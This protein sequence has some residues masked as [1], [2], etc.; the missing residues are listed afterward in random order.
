MLNT[1]A[2]PLRAL[3]F[4]AGG[5]A[6]AWLWFNVGW[7]APL[8]AVALVVGASLALQ[9]AGKRL[10]PVDPERALSYLESRAVGIA[11]ITAAF[12]AA[13]IVCTVA[14]TTPDT[15]VT[16]TK[17]I[18][19]TLSA[20]IVAFLSGVA[21]PSDEADEEIGE[22]VRE[23]FQSVYVRQSDKPTPG[24][25]QLITGSTAHRAIQSSLDFGLNDWSRAN[26]RKRIELLVKGKETDWVQ[27]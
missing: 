21:I 3:V 22:H 26:R 10:V 11:A 24:K 20:A 27:A 23:L 16:S 9:E 13:G 17:E 8:I 18:I 4:S 25:V 7:W 5:A 15:M 14:L 19:S 12:G 1:L 6:L 2:K